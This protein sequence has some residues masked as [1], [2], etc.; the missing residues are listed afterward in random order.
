MGLL[1]HNYH[2]N[3]RNLTVTEEGVAIVDD[4]WTLRFIEADT[5]HLRWAVELS[6]PVDT[7]AS[8]EAKVYAA[9]DA[10][11]IVEAYDLK[12]GELAWKADITLPSGSGYYLNLQER[13][14]YV[15]Q[16]GKEEAI[17]IFDRQTGKNLDKIRIL[18]IG[19]RSA[20]LLLSKDQEWLQSTDEAVV[21]VK[22]G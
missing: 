21:F 14:L 11:Q 22:A 12:T 18:D 2:R 10:G 8:D 15:Y 13:G 4:T 3:A 7:L 19:P 17:Y 6:G 1:Q 20:N 16:L 9:G 5:G